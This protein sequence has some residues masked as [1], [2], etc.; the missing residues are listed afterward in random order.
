MD[1]HMIRDLISDLIVESETIFMAGRV[2]L[3]FCAMMVVFVVVM[4]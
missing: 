3:V 1:D 4:A 2:A